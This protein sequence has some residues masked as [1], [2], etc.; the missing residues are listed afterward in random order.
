[1]VDQVGIAF[2]QRRNGCI[3]GVTRASLQPLQDQN[4]MAFVLAD[5]S[6]DGLKCFA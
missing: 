2:T 3:L 6:A 5:A 4:A 1:M